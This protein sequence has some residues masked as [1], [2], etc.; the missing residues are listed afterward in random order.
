MDVEYTGI[1]IYKNLP[2]GISRT[3]T[4]LGIT[5]DKDNNPVIVLNFH[6]NNKEEYDKVMSSFI[7]K[8]C[9]QKAIE[10]FS[11]E[12]YDNVSTSTKRE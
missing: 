12:V 6:T 7:C 2:E 4:N 1:I 8:S 10:N 11:I 9:L 5:V 3:N